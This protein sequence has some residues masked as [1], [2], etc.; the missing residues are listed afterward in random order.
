MV[1]TLVLVAVVALVAVGAGRLNRQAPQVHDTPARVATTWAPWSV[2]DPPSTEPDLADPTVSAPTGVYPTP[3][4]SDPGSTPGAGA[5]TGPPTRAP[6]ATAGQPAAGQSMPN[7]QL[8]TGVGCPDAANASYY[9]AYEAG[10]PVATLVGGFAGGS[11]AGWFWSVPMSGSASTDDPDTYVLWSFTI[12][13]PA[14]GKCDIWAFVPQGASP[15]DV[16]GKPTTYKVVR[17]RDDLGQ[18]GTFTI[19]QTAHRGHWVDGGSFPYSGGQIA[20]QMV[21]RG[22]GSGGG[23]HGAA[24]VGINCTA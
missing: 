5:T 17:S 20:V 12:A 9:A 15:Q 11:C 2:T 3:T 21:N 18:I 14:Q 8:L 16:A 4:D 13:A 6:T 1:A 22:T 7:L 23:R 10:A 24:Q 19:D